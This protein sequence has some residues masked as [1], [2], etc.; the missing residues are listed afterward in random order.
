MTRPFTLK[1]LL[2][3]HKSPPL[4]FFLF[5]GFEDLILRQRAEAR[6]ASEEQH[7]SWFHSS[8][9]VL[10]HVKPCISQHETASAQTTALNV[11]AAEAIGL[12]RDEEQPS[13]TKRARDPT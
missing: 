6:A 13:V 10:T 11:E 7:P 8:K 4:L 1:L 9:N 12:V 5:A 3:Q 2:L